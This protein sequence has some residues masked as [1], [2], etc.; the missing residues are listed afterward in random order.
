M[1][2]FSV[3]NFP[4]AFNTRYSQKGCWDVLQN[5]R[6]VHALLQFDSVF[7]KGILFDQ[8]NLLLSRDHGPVDYLDCSLLIQS[9]NALRHRLQSDGNIFRVLLDNGQ[10]HQLQ[11]ILRYWRSVPSW[12]HRAYNLGFNVAWPTS[13]QENAEIGYAEIH[14]S[15]AGKPNLSRVL[16]H[17][18]N[19]RN[20]EKRTT[21]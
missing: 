19:D 8:R 12:C 3:G 11:I 1:L 16:K 17:S 21:N 6:R 2:N 20:T 10:V 14:G 9:K 7:Q 15:W 5:L 4:F 18:W 13:Y